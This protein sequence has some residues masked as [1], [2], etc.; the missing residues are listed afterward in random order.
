M[1]LAKVE[2]SMGRRGLP[3]TESCVL[4][5]DDDVCGVADLRDRAVFDGDFVEAFEDYGFHCG[6]RHAGR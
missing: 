1:E 5:F 4:Y 2:R 3:S 6:W